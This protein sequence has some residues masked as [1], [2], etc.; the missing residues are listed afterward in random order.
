MPISIKGGFP[1]SHSDASALLSAA[2]STFAAEL[3]RRSPGSVAIIRKHQIP[4]RG[5][6]MD[7]DIEEMGR[8]LLEHLPHLLSKQ[9]E[10]SASRIVIEAQ[11]E[12]FAQAMEQAKDAHAAEAMRVEL[13]ELRPSALEKRAREA[14]ASEELLEEAKDADDPRQR[15]VELIMSMSQV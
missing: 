8:T 12:D 3:D 9:F 7:V 11:L 2:D 6:F 4:V 14:G 5:V 10:P 15:M 1:Y 13:L